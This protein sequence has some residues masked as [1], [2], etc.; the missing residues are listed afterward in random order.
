MLLDLT[1]GGRPIHIYLER[2][3]NRYA[4]WQW[5]E[6]PREAP[7]IGLPQTLRHGDLIVGWSTWLRL[8]DV[9]YPER[10]RLVGHNVD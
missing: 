4:C 9:V 6:P 8:L 2:C 7:H 3:L 1:I 10:E 5:R